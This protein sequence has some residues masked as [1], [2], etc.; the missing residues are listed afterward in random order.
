MQRAQA[1]TGNLS[2]LAERTEWISILA[3]FLGRISGLW[4][5]RAGAEGKIAARY[6]GC[7]WCDSTEHQLSNDIMTG[8]RSRY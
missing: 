4:Q 6:D 5:N 1:T 8:I 7:A 2:V 3:K